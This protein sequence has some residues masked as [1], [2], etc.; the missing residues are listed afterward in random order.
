MT[1]AFLNLSSHNHPCASKSSSSRACISPSMVYSLINTSLQASNPIPSEHKSQDGTL[2]LMPSQ[3][4]MARANPTSST[5]YASFSVSRTCPRY[6][7]SSLVFS[8]SQFNAFCHPRCVQ[9]ISKI[10]FTSVAKPELPKPA[11][12]S[13]STTLIERTVLWDLRTISRS[14]SLVRS[15]VTSYNVL[16]SPNPQY[17]QIALPNVSKYLLNGHKALQANVQTLFQSVQLNIN[18]P[19]F[20]I[21]QGRITKVR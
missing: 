17:P 20:V 5:R 4:L 12:P 18:N 9:R 16:S 19:N 11:L 6:I 7:Y 14:P 21:M 15:V 2:R 1:D 8:F 3:G 13:Y 10:S